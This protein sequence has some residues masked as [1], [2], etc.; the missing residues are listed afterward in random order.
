MEKEDRKAIQV[1]KSIN[2]GS[3][4]TEENI[5]HLFFK[6]TSESLKDDSKAL[7]NTSFLS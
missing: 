1:S 4:P 6:K 2:Q 5:A 7:K 3:K